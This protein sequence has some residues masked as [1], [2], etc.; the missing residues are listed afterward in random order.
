MAKVHMWDN[1]TSKART[2]R[3]KDVSVEVRIEVRRKRNVFGCT[4][5]NPKRAVDGIFQR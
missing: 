4:W 2:F 1:K 5:D 3:A